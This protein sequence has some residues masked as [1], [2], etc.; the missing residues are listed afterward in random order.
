M[1]AGNRLNVGLDE[2]AE[3]S[4]SMISALYNGAMRPLKEEVRGLMVLMDRGE[5]AEVLAARARA[6]AVRWIAVMVALVVFW[7]L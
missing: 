4:S 1:P 2:R 3:R 5:K 7:T 6:A